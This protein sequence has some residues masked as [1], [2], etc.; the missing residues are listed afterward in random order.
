MF[1]DDRLSHGY[2]NLTRRLA[3]SPVVEKIYSGS[4]ALIRVDREAEC[5]ERVAGVLPVPDVLGRDEGRNL[6][7]LEWIAGV[8]GQ[9]LLSDGSA[10]EV[11]NA[12]GALLRHLQEQATPLL[13]PVLPGAGTSAVHGDFGP[14]NLVFSVDRC[15][16]AL[17]DWE[18]ARMGD[19]I[20][21]VA[22]AEWIVRMHHPVATGA[23]DALFVGYG[24][25]PDWLVRHAAMLKQC[26]RMRQRCAAEGLLDAEAMWRERLTATTGWS[27]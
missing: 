26:E 25:H 3:G 23:L 6:L 7:R 13:A 27:D 10:P 14:Q 21:D 18:F 12:T 22:W 5:L 17:V 16:V 24:Q 4:D 15:V 2:T 11:L 8:P 19:P 20:E 9:Q 1:A